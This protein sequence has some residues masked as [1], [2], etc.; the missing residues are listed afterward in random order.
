[1]ELESKKRQ[2]KQNIVIT[3]EG[4]KA[5]QE[6]E[7]LLKQ[8][9]K[10]VVIDDKT[11]AGDLVEMILSLDEKIYFEEAKVI[12][13]QFRFRAFR[14]SEPTFIVRNISLPKIEPMARLVENHGPIGAIIKKRKF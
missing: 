10:V 9:I 6:I 14:T 5:H 1:M 3:G 13:E 4:T 7:K 8:G 2:M 11:T 12:V